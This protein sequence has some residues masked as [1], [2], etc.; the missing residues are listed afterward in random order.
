[1]LVVGLCQRSRTA[2]PSGIKV[3]VILMGTGNT[4]SSKVAEIR[5]ENKSSICKKKKYA[6][7][8]VASCKS[9]DQSDWVLSGVGSYCL[10]RKR[11]LYI[12]VDSIHWAS[13][14]NVLSIF[15]ISTT[16]A[17]NVILEDTILK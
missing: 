3:K 2:L 5:A 11:T 10:H 13:G 7:F 14:E 16:F 8:L 9:Y 17:M 12:R 1:M 6:N 4:K 15:F